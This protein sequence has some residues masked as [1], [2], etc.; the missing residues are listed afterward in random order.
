MRR[1]VESSGQAHSQHDDQ[2]VSSH[3]N[4][5]DTVLTLR[6]MCPTNSMCCGLVG[7]QMGRWEKGERKKKVFALGLPLLPSPFLFFLFWWV[8]CEK[9]A[10][11]FPSPPPWQFLSYLIF[12]KLHEIWKKKMCRTKHHLNCVCNFWGGICRTSFLLECA[13]KVFFSP[14]KIYR[15]LTERVCTVQVV[16]K[17]VT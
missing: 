4:F 11:F 12:A 8:S 15:W 9:K 17:W 1:Y 10:N 16:G 6:R 5:F 3:H 7:M 14:K 13:S 2:H